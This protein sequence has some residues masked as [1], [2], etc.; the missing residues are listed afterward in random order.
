M[1]YGSRVRPFLPWLQLLAIACALLAGCQG[2][3]LGVS[4]RQVPENKRVAL[5]EGAETKGIWA[6]PELKVKYT[7][8]KERD[9][10]D[11]TVNIEFEETYKTIFNT[12]RHLSVQAFFTDDRGNIIGDKGVLTEGNTEIN[13][14]HTQSVKLKL[15]AGA[16][17]LSFGYTG[18]LYGNT[19]LSGVGSISYYPN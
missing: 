11:L 8:I 17:S 12:V 15:P 9:D 14:N 2:S 1:A 7:Y 16:S 3:F 10:L 18:E 4:H 19:S 5:V 6:G 13:G